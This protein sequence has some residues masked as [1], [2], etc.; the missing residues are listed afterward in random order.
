[1]DSVAS[2]GLPPY[3][4]M[5]VAMF[6]NVLAFAYDF[7][8]SL[9]KRIGSTLWWFIP[10]FT[11]CIRKLTLMD[12]CLQCDDVGSFLSMNNDGYHGETWED[13]VGNFTQGEHSLRWFL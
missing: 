7:W 13:G 2:A 6:D 4:Q 12:R 10:S 9:S 1:M 8:S 3:F 5:K 11:I